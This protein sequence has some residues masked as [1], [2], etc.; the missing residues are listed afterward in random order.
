MASGIAKGSNELIKQTVLNP[1]VRFSPHH[2]REGRLLLRT[3][4]KNMNDP[5]AAFTIQHMRDKI[6]F[7]TGKTKGGK[8]IGL[9]G[10]LGKEG[11]TS[12]SILLGLT[13]SELKRNRVVFIDGRMER[14]LFALYS[15]MFGLTKNALNYNNGCG[16]FQCYNTKNRN[17]C[18]LTP[19]AAME[20]LEIFSNNEFV[21]LMGDLR[22]AFD[23]IVFDMP[24]VLGSSESRM[25]LPYLDLF[26]LVCAAGK[27]TFS[28]VEK[29]KKMVGEVGGTI[30]GVLMNRQKVP[31][32]AW[33]FGKDTF[34]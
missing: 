5:E 4:R 1:L 26:F 16:F 14:R 3:L 8:A 32:W 12:L 25:I 23:Y 27:T 33:L 18:F 31:F 13:L 6:F 28:E 24:P 10:P 22:E 15:E 30:S 29:S 20:P 19:G 7:H 17:L 21:H 11:A 9:S 34:F 2:K